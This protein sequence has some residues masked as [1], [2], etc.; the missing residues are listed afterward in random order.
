MKTIT[1]NI[2]I[3]RLFIFATNLLFIAGLSGCTSTPNVRKSGNDTSGAPKPTI[4]RSKNPANF[5]I[6]AS[7]IG[8][9][10]GAVI[11]K[12]M[13]KQATALN[14]DLSGI[15]LVERIGEGIKITVSS[16]VL[17]ESDSYALSN[18]PQE[19]LK[20]MA[21][22]LINYKDTEL[23][24]AGHTDGTGDAKQNQILSEKRAE[25]LADFLLAHNVPQLR[26]VT[27]GFGEQTPKVSNGTD[28]GRR[29]NQRV[30]IAIVA[31]QTLK[32]DAK[33]QAEQDKISKKNG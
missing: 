4:S 14:R 26:M 15:A 24:I 33:R 10:A 6:V 7:T 17:F 32:K 19:Q 9:A 20:K 28:E 18:T 21:E 13:E 31:N 29:M 3:K 12:Y 30:E 25:S 27:Q 16:V 2:P 8:G 11:E 22:T 5:A 1:I 23:L